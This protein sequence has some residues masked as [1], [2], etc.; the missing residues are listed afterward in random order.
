VRSKSSALAAIFRRN[1]GAV[2]PSSG[3]GRLQPGA[4]T[5]LELYGP[6][7]RARAELKAASETGVGDVAQ[8]AP[9]VPGVEPGAHVL[10]PSTDTSSSKPQEV[11]RQGDVAVLQSELEMIIAERERLQQLARLDAREAEL[12]RM[13][14]ERLGG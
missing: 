13:I 8:A 4:T 14:R 6:S 5:P 12:E 11:A 9:P 2:P 7:S 10:A 1:R 3:P